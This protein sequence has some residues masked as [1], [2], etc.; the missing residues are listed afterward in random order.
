MTH[1]IPPVLLDGIHLAFCDESPDELGHGRGRRGVQLK[2]ERDIIG[3]RVEEVSEPPEELKRE[4]EEI[5]SRAQDE[6]GVQGGDGASA[7]RE[8]EEVGVA[9]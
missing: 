2:V 8:G 5:V 1:E 4:L 3:G 9:V 6:D 7:R